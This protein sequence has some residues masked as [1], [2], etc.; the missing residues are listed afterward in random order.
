MNYRLLKHLPGYKDNKVPSGTIFRP[1]A[2]DA[3]WFVSE[4]PR[5]LME[6]IVVENSP[7]LFAPVHEPVYPI[8]A[9]TIAPL[10]YVTPHFE[11]DTTQAKSIDTP[12]YW[13]TRNDAAAFAIYCRNGAVVLQNRFNLIAQGWLPSY[14]DTCYY[15][16]FDGHKTR[17]V[18][19]ITFDTSKSFHA[20][21]LE[22]CR[23]WPTE[24]MALEDLEAQETT[25]ITD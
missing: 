8:P 24:E 20:A 19:E 16:A 9:P 25:V 17:E 13:H 7:W 6:R 5:H 2:N 12:S 11:V 10:Y 21:L 15:V 22:G 23:L 1:D 18:K 3:A 4:N 14:G